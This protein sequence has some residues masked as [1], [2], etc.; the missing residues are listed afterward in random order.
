MNIRGLAS[1]VLPYFK[2]KEGAKT[3]LVRTCSTVDYYLRLP[4]TWILIGLVSCHTSYCD[5]LAW[6]MVSIGHHLHP[7]YISIHWRLV[8]IRNLLILIIVL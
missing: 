7:P 6:V 2:N 3:D 8:P 4:Q 1:R 5:V